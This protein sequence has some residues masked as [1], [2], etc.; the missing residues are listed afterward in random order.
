MAMVSSTQVTRESDGRSP[1]SVTSQRLDEGSRVASAAARSTTAV[2][3]T[4]RTAMAATRRWLAG[5]TC[6]ASRTQCHSSQPP[7]H[8]S[9]FEACASSKIIDRQGDTA[10]TTC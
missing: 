4:I 1:T 3:K 7:R 8:L 9:L 10:T 5:E 6:V 2:A